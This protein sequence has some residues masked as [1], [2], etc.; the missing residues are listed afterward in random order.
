MVVVVAG[1]P[2]VPVPGVDPGA[3][4]L[5][6]VVVGAP[7]EPPMVVVVVVVVDLP[8]VVVAPRRVVDVDDPAG[9]VVVVV[10]EVVVDVLVVVVLTGT[11]PGAYTGPSG[12]LTMAPP[13]VDA[14]LCGGLKYRT[15][16]N[17]RKATAISSVDRRMGKR[18][19][20]GTDMYPTSALCLAASSS[21]LF[22][23]HGAR[24]AGARAGSSSSPSSVDPLPESPVG[25]L[26]RSRPRWLAS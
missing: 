9:R 5:V 13:E 17:P 7:P 12:P 1:D 15:V 20:T 6:V 2:T 18:R 3:V 24:A 16:P 10:D 21:A 14:A 25:S 26:I 8:D 23:A 19:W 4:V 11:A 22:L